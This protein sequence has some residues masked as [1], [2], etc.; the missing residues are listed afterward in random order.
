LDIISQ[1]N[2]EAVF[3]EELGYDSYFPEYPSESHHWK[4]PIMITLAVKEVYHIIYLA[5]VSSHIMGDITSGMNGKLTL[6]WT[7][8]KYLLVPDRNK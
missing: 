2:A 3:F 5:R 1:N 8:V 6:K 7:G 4:S